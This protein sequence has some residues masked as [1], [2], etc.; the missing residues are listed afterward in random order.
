MP[1]SISPVRSMACVLAAGCLLAAAR[2]GELPPRPTFDRD[3]MPILTARGC[4]Q[5]ACHG[6]SGGQNGFALSL[7]GFDPD[8]DYHAVTAQGRGR[9]LSV[10]APE[11]SLLLAKGTAA[12]P[13]GGGRKLDPDGDDVRLLVR[14]IESGTPRAEIGRAHV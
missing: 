12:V 11:E 1:A 6:K 8:G 10:A 9:R 7:L 14:W 3:V 2:A 5:A 4:N 13:H